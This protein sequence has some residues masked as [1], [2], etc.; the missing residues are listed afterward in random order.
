MK[1]RLPPTLPFCGCLLL[2]GSG[3]SLVPI[4]VPRTLPDPIR[5]VEVVGEGSE[6]PVTNAEVVVYADRDKNWLRSFPPYYVAEFHPPQANSVV[7]RLEPAGPGRFS[8]ERRH[9]WRYIWPWGIGPLGTALHEDY[10]VSVSARADGFEPVTA[11][12]WPQGGMNSEAAF[13]PGSTRFTPPRFGTNG[14]LTVLL[15]ALDTGASGPVQASQPIGSGTN[16]VL[17]AVGSPTCSPSCSYSTSCS[18]AER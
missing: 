12:Y 1:L 6:Q 10:A 2:L 17:P 3:C 7:L 11:T 5:Q 16:A 4:P 15:K 9:V 14:V 8:V 13:A 18:C